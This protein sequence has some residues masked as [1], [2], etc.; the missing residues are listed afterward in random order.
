LEIE[1]IGRAYKAA[2][3]YTRADERK[4][5][6]YCEQAVERNYEGVRSMPPIQ[7]AAKAITQRAKYG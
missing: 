6:T 3:D 2:E 1:E 4:I 7:A 5:S